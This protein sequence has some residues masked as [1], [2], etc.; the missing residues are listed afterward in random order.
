[1]KKLTPNLMVKDVAETVRFYVEILNFEPVAL[2]AEDRST[3]K[4]IEPGKLYAWGMVKSD[5]VELMFLSEKSSR[6]ELKGLPDTLGFSGTLYLET[7]KVEEFYA[8]LSGKVEIV[9]PL[10]VSW[11]GMKEFYIRDSNG[12][13]L[14]FSEAPSDSMNCPMDEDKNAPH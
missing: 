12:Y 2:V 14:A 6:E 9:K 11:Y 4:S 8:R 1:M 3:D 5:S 13:L 7:E 10:A